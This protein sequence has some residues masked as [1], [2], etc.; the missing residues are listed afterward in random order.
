L[1]WALRTRIDETAIIDSTGVFWMEFLRRR[2][3]FISLIVSAAAAWPFAAGAQQP[4][5]PVVGFLNGGSPKAYARPLSAFLKGLAETGYV[6]GRNVAIEYRWAEGQYDR[7]PAF[8]ADFVTRKV[9]V[10]AGTSTQGGLA[11][12]AVTSTIPV[13]FT[14]SGDPVQLGL[15]SSLSRPDGNVTGA[16][17]LNV[18]VA[19]KR[20]ELMHEVLPAAANFAL[21]IN[22][23]SSLAG[24]V[25]RDLQAA[26]DSRRLKLHILNASSERDFAAVFATLAQLRADALVIGTDTFFTSRS[27]EL[28]TLVVRQRVPAIYQYPEFTTAGGLMSYGGT[29]TESYRLAGIYAGRILKGEKPGDLPVQQVTKVELIINLKS[30]KALGITFPI[31]L[32]GRADE[33]I[34]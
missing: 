1:P 14:T 7:L 2:H 11:A 28:A 5:M 29:I 24:R 33:V 23:T 22:P 9:N 16:S 34:E 18:E 4:A 30:A 27:E 10:I 32:L 13:V 6:E 17:Q 3:A 21:L 8:A 25:S 31:S 12:K 15:V 19:P 20:L 26:A